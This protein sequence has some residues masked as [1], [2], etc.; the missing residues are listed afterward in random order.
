LGIYSCLYF[1]FP[2]RGA[3][4]KIFAMSTLLE[5]KIERL[6]RLLMD[7][8][9]HDPVAGAF[10]RALSAERFTFKHEP[11]HRTESCRHNN[12]QRPPS[13]LVI[14]AHDEDGTPLR[15]L[16][17]I[18]RLYEMGHHKTLDHLI[19]L[20]ALQFTVAQDIAPVSIN[21]SSRHTEDASFWMGLHDDVETFFSDSIS[22]DEIIFELLEDYTPVAIDHD[23]LD[24][25]QGLGYRFA[26][27]DMSDDP[28]DRLRQWLLLPYCQFAKIDGATVERMLEKATTPDIEDLKNMLATRL[29]Q[30]GAIVME[31]VQTPNDADRLRRDFNAR[32]VQGYPLN[33]SVFEDFR[34]SMPGALEPVFDK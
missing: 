7:V 22:P 11:L 15:P 31:R 10:V 14:R 34:N 16:E 32:H 20:Q 26:L 13:E 17:P 25:M 1:F 9:G 2:P 4:G 12:V 24:L 19:V 23:A 8:A 28:A 27:D 18:S 30:D 21:V 6:T 33:K 5:T 29:P 3:Y